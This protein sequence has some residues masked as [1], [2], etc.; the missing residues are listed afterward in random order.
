[1]TTSGRPSPDRSP[2]AM[3]TRVEVAVV[4]LRQV[5]AAV[6]AERAV[7]EVHDPL[8]GG[9]GERSRRCT[10][11][12]FTSANGH[13]INPRYR[14]TA[15]SRP[16][17]GPPSGGVEPVVVDRVLPGGQAVN[18]LPHDGRRGRRHGRGRRARPTPCPSGTGRVLE[19]TSPGGKNGSEA[20]DPHHLR[21]HPRWMTSLGG[22]PARAPVEIAEVERGPR[23]ACRDGTRAPFGIEVVADAQLAKEVHRRTLK[24]RAAGRVCRPR[25]PSA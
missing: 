3:L 17:R 12:P 5:T 13:G 9:A 21:A 6:E 20:E 22:T 16:T 8:P 2:T 25:T 11:S 7:A 23:P 24:P 4:E 10:Q 15:V 1:M 19:P 14:R 18:V